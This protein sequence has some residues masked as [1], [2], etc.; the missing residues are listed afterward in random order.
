LPVL[1]VPVDT[2][3]KKASFVRVAEENR[4]ARAE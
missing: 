1:F 2:L 4:R 3:R